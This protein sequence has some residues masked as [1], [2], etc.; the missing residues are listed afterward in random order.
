MMLNLLDS[1]DTHRF[2]TE[3]GCNKDKLK[4]AIALTMV[5]TGTPCL[6]YGTEIAIEGGYD[7][8]SRRCFDWQE[9]N[10][11]KQL[12]QEISNLIMLKKHEEILHY[13]QIKITTMDDMLRV[14]REHNFKRIILYN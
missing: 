10:W 14:E 1:H 2:F 3:I 12:W 9:Q 11:D 6:Y 8:D 4:S 5:L 7:P 13:G